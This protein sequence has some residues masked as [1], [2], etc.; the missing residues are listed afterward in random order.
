M[1]DRERFVADCQAAVGPGVHP[2]VLREVVA[3]A[4]D[5]PAALMQVLGEPQPGPPGVLHRAG[6]LTIINVCWKPGMVV[7]PHNH[8]MAAVIGVYVG[9]EDNILW[10]RL[11]EATE[12]RIEAAGAKTLGVRDVFA[13][14]QDIIHSVVNPTSRVTGAIHVYRGDFFGVPRSEWDPESLVEKPYDMAKVMRMFAA[15]QE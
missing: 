9:R 3:R 12:G 6:D 2:R 15:A 10:R 7:M 14:G 8:E 11:P 13:L 5:D 1:F 4:V